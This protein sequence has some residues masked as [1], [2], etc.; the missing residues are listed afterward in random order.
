MARRFLD[1]E[2]LMLD[3]FR[4][5]VKVFESGFRPT[6]IVDLWRGGAPVGIVVQE[7]LQTLGV[8]ADHIALRT[9]RQTQADGSTRHRVHGTQY[10]LETLVAADQLLIVDD[11]YSTG[12]TVHAVIERLRQRLKRNMPEDVRI[13]VPWHRPTPGP[14]PAPDYA[15]HETRDELIF[16]WELEGL[17]DEEI[18]EHKPF[19]APLLADQP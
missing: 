2:E 1:E 18:T 16:P 3:G 17:S 14:N 19:L 6:F 10:L 9:S 15:L 11:A 12:H 8:Q 4:L 13:A 7:C 5:G